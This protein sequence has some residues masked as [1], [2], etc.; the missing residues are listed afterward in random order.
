MWHCVVPM[1]IACDDVILC[2]QAGYF[3]VCDSGDG[4]MV[5]VLG[6]LRDDQVQFGGFRVTGVDNKGTVKSTR[7]KFIFFTWIGSSVPTMEKLNARA[8]PSDVFHGAHVEFSG[9]EDRSALTEESVIAKLRAAGGAHQPDYYD[10]SNAEARAHIKKKK[11]KSKK[12]KHAT[13]VDEEEMGGIWERV[14]SSKKKDRDF[15]WA[16]FACVL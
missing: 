11:K 13:T 6:R 4:G 10:F 7:G 12:S 14:L 16:M 2:T 8:V 1:S 3:V 15:Q 9:L 5:D